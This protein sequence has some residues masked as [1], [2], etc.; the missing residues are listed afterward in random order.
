LSRG[1]GPK[2]SR[3]AL[4]FQVPDRVSIST[5]A[6][7]AALDLY[8]NVTPQERL[9]GESPHDLVFGRRGDQ[10]STVQ[11]EE[12]QDCSLPVPACAA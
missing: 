10:T 9:G 12:L 2:E 8:K 4:M 1:R 5:M 7:A 6:T 11:I 3:K